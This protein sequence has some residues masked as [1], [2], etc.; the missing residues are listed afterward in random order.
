MDGQQLNTYLGGIALIS[1]SN[2]YAI[3]EASL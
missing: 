3:I 1:N 2:A